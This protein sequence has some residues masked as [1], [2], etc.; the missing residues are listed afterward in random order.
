LN[1]GTALIKGVTDATGKTETLLKLIPDIG[2]IEKL[3]K[4]NQTLMEKYDI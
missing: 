1:S 3:L 4:I 2:D